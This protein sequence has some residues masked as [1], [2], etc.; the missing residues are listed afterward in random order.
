M[1]FLY[2]YT[3]MTG[4]TTWTFLTIFFF[5]TYS[6]W[7][8]RLWAFILHCSNVSVPNLEVVDTSKF[9]S[10]ILYLTQK[11]KRNHETCQAE[12]FRPGLVQFS[13]QKMSSY[14][15]KILFYHNNNIL[16][17]VPLSFL[18]GTYH[19]FTWEYAF[20]RIQEKN[21]RIFG[22]I[23]WESGSWLKH[24]APPQAQ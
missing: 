14:I 17:V 5:G 8:P 15:C 7:F 12:H 3:K 11:I 6:W 2:Q 23:L 16:T 13:L 10:K 18:T 20:C 22:N 24:P 9:Y 21:I 1:D 19:F 4:R